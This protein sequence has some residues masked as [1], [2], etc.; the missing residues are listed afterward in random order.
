LARH[1]FPDQE[2]LVEAVRHILE[3]IETVNLNRI[4]LANGM[5]S[6][7]NHYVTDIPFPLLDNARPH[8]ARVILEFLKQNG[9][10]KHATHHA[11]L[12]WHLLTLTSYF[13]AHIK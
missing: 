12:I 5:K 9:M 8:T 4:V 10:K 3:G 1:E 11:H 6:K 13:F 7:G 2:A